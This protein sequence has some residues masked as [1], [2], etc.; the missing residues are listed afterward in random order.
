MEGATISIDSTLMSG[1][2]GVSLGVV[3][4]GSTNVPACDNVDEDGLCDNFNDDC[5][6]AGD[7]AGDCNGDVVVLTY[8][9][10]SDGDGFCR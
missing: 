4:P 3:G 10:D 8:Y 5:V 9:L 7:C 2:G 1:E 6:G